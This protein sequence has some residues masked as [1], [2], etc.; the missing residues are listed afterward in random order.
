MLT[1]RC[2]KQNILGFQQGEDYYA[3]VL[4][5]RSLDSPSPSSVQAA[6]AS[7]TNGT[8][9]KTIAVLA[10]S[11]LCCFKNLLEEIMSQILSKI[12]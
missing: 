1:K 9:K 5:H 12:M 11:L 3:L 4:L 8:S 2:K 10:S 6:A 7:V